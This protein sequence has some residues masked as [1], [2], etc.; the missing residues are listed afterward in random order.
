V[1]I[2]LHGTGCPTLLGVTVG[3]Q[4][5]KDVVDERPAVGGDLRWD[6]E[7]TLVEGPDLRGPFVQG[8][9]GA[10]FLY[11]SWMHSGAMF[12]RAKLMLDEVPPDLLAADPATG[13]QG[14][15]PLTL[16]DGSPICAA[17]RPPSIS[18]SAA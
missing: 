3:L 2:K 17:I 1:L 14:L 11:L 7:V 6:F 5:V 16:P 9:R 12:R 13:I 4:R 8:R 10:R 18:W 15:F